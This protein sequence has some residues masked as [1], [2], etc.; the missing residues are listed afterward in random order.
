MEVVEADRALRLK[1]NEPDG[2]FGLEGGFFEDVLLSYT[3]I[4]DYLKVAPAH[5]YWLAK[6]RRIRA[7][8][9]TDADCRLFTDTAVADRRALNVDFWAIFRKRLHRDW[10][11]ALRT[12]F[13]PAAPRAVR[14][15]GGARHRAR[16]AAPCAGSRARPDAWGPQR[17]SKHG[18]L[19]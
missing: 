12:L 8:C 11:A 17:Y 19:R 15:A 6:R 13:R 2:K 7:L 5:L 9:A 3:S 4:Y 14:I 18:A 1:L 10:K 16:V